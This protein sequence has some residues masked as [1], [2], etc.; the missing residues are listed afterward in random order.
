MEEMLEKSVKKQKN[1]KHMKRY[2]LKPDVIYLKNKQDAI[3]TS[4]EK[5][6]SFYPQ[7]EYGYFGGFS[8]SRKD[9]YTNEELSRKYRE[10]QRRRKMD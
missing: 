2:M 6:K 4:T 9:I 5:K 1:A 10:E 7:D 8:P 3:L